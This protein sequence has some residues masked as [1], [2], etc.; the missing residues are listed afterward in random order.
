[1]SECGWF[2]AL[3]TK[4]IGRIITVVDELWLAFQRPEYELNHMSAML[5][6]TLTSLF[7]MQHKE[8]QIF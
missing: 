3:S 1:M 2:I 8:A 7:Y 5:V 6:T 4:V